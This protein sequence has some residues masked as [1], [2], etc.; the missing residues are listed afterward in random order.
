[1]R[2]EEMKDVEKRKEGVPVRRSEYR[3][4]TM[5][6]DDFKRFVDRAAGGFI[7][8][9]RLGLWHHPSLHKEWAP[10]ID[11][12][13]REGKIVVRADLP[14]MKREDIEVAV[15]DN[16]LVV[17][18]HRHEEKE[19]NEGDYRRTERATGDFY[20]AVSLPEGVDG[21]AIE[22]TYTDGVLE[23]TVPVPAAPEPKKLKVAVK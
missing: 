17:K 14:G 1:M 16:M 3:R 7:P 10:N 13:E 5:W 8:W 22:A 9:P 4:Q 23:V 20:R 12:L 11:V 15:E 2:D 6:P 18:G 21:D 19:I